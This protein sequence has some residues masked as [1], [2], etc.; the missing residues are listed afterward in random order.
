MLAFYVRFSQMIAISSFIYC[1]IFI[2]FSYHF[3]SFSRN[4]PIKNSDFLAFLL[5]FLVFACL[6][7]VLL[8]AAFPC[9]FTRFIVLH[10]NHRSYL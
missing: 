1:F 9:I 3:I 4:N 5:I 8:F 10:K 6:I 7:F 2:S